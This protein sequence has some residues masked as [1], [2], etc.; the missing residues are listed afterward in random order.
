MLKKKTSFTDLIFGGF[1]VRFKL[2]HFLKILLSLQV[3]L[4]LKSESYLAERS[5]QECLLFIQLDLFPL[6][7]FLISKGL[8]KREKFCCDHRNA[9]Y[10]QTIFSCNF[11][12]VLLVKIN[13]LAPSLRYAFTPFSPKFLFSFRLSSSS[14]HFP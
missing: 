1:I 6:D 4:Q 12:Q 13:A 9:G 3:L 11:F 7:I 10:F 14:L 8:G 2:Q 5:K